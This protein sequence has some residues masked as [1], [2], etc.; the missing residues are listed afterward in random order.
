M[1]S[2]SEVTPA[3]CSR[4]L[5]IQRWPRCF[6][7]TS[8]WCPLMVAGS[9]LSTCT[10]PSCWD[11]KF[12]WRGKYL[13]V[14][15]FKKN[16]HLVQ[17]WPWMCKMS[18]WVGREK[19]CIFVFFSWC[20]IVNCSLIILSQSHAS[21]LYDIFLRLCQ[22][23]AHLDPTHDKVRGDDLTS[24]ADQSPDF[25]ESLPATST[26]SIACYTRLLP[27]FCDTGR[28]PSRSLPNNQLK[29]LINVSPDSGIL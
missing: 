6:L 4:L 1:S 28:R 25:P 21:T 5:P 12:F 15:F 14:A 19:P 2:F 18:R 13:I 29:I 8:T 9:Y 22:E 27:N 17:F 7:G 24:K 20:V 3:G 10:F 16:K 26:S 23:P 11:Y